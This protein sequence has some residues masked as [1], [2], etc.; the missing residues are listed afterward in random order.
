MDL[1]KLTS[2]VH[3]LF[4]ED[5][6]EGREIDADNVLRRIESEHPESLTAEGARL[7]RT[8]CRRLI[9]NEMRRMAAMNPATDDGPQVSLPGLERI[10]SHVM[11]TNLAGKVVG[12]NVMDA[13][14]VQ[15]MACLELKR[16]NTQRCIEREG[17]QERIIDL[18]KSSGCNTLKEWAEQHANAQPDGVTTP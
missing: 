9:T 17:Q 14:K 12:R 1:E 18:L 6:A 7:V 3:R 10:P 11:F 4:R 16:L 15:H 2:I 13:T 8:A 5:D